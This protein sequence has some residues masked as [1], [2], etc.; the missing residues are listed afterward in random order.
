MAG[1]SRA[2][3]RVR[4]RPVTPTAVS[5]FAGVGGMD[6]GFS[7]AGYTVVIANEIDSAACMSYRANWP[8]TPLIEGSIDE[9]RTLAELSACGGSASVVFG[10]PPCQGFSVAGRMD[11]ADARSRLLWRFF[12]VI[13][14]LRPTAFVCENVKA[15]GAHARWAALRADM[16][17]QAV[18]HGYCAAFIVVNARDYGVPQNRERMFLVGFRDDRIA[19]PSGTALQSALYAHLG[20][21]RRPAH[22]TAQ[23]LRAC[24]RAGS[25]GNARA[26]RAKVT[27]AK[28]P[29]LRPSPY[30]GM[31]FNGIGRPIR[32]YGA[33]ATLPASMGGNRTPIV[34]DDEI[35]GGAPSYIEAYHRHLRNGGAPRQ[36]TA[37]ARLRRLTVDEC[38]AIQTFPPGTSLC[39]PMTAMYRQ[40]GN[41]VPPRLAHAVACAVGDIIDTGTVAGLA[42]FAA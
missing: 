23:I 4:M 25:P 14:Q 32:P 39:G 2:S 29:V 11:P 15:L 16:L 31:L 18:E 26:C 13:G 35:F 9:E 20:R 19:I 6:I 24:G 36:G 12:D 17:R 38:L 28:R 41:A 5:L 34:D 33:S 10:G 40:I 30:A 3:V 27:F 42:L 8:E 22:S 37:P 21:H 7:N 1:T